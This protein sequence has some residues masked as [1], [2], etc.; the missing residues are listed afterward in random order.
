MNKLKNRYN[1]LSIQSKATLWYTIGNVLIKGVSLL[2]TPIFARVMSQEQY[3]T[4]T[5]FQSWYNI[6]IIFTSL[7][8]FLG[9][10]TKG[11]L[12]YKDKIDE[13]TSSSLGL[14]LFLT[15]IFLLIYLLNAKFWSN[16]FSLSPF[17]MVAMFLELFLMPAF[18]FWAARARFEYKYERLV[19]ISI[20]SA[21]SSVILGVIA[22]LL[23]SNKTA[24]RVYSDAFVKGTIGLFF[25]LYLV[26]KGKK[27]F[28]KKV[29]IYNI[30][31]NVPLIPHYLS[32]YALNQAD[33][34]M[35]SKMVGRAQAANYSIAYTISMMMTII[36]NA[37]TNA[38]TPLIYK[39]INNK[40]IRLIKNSTRSL[41]VI[42]SMLCIVTMAFAPELIVIFAGEK[43]KQAIPIV[44]PVAASVYFI[45]LY[46]MFSTIEYY[47]QKTVYIS[48]AT[49]FSAGINVVL[50]F[51]FINIFGY[52]AAG[53]ITLI[54]YIILSFM[55]YLFSKKIVKTKLSATQNI[56]DI[57][58]ISLFAVFT[59]IIMLLL[60]VMYNSLVLRYGTLI[61]FGIVAL[62]KRKQLI[63][64]FNNFKEK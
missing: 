14:D 58:M 7:N 31:F 22:V 36:I 34:L 12:I 27:L 53:Y 3:G 46:N 60:A 39:S 30:K 37:I 56:Y 16:L 26:K 33:L 47:F 2:S 51:I 62:I 11:L 45:F 21:I 17:L 23:S 52:Y 42:V 32:N 1:K 40:D 9:G 15:S 63:K 5:M 18:E 50:N 64:I 29:W 59:L 43:Y 24:A 4:Y 35:I 61:T 48:L 20:I 38:I 28:D 55:H 57:K 13:F 44:P 10:Y 8:L 25:V 41:F 19:Q 54:S 49:L 6:F